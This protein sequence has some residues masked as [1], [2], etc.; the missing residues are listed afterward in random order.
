VFG[1]IFPSAS[2]SG[3]DSIY[4]LTRLGAFM[5]PGTATFTRL[6]VQFSNCRFVIHVPLIIAAIVIVVVAGSGCATIA[7]IEVAA[8]Q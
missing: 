3:V 1:W 4:L 2:F 5:P 6:T 8:V 7:I